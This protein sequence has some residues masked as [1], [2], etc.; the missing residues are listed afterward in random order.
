MKNL[1]TKQGQWKLKCV[2]KDGIKY[3]VSDGKSSRKNSWVTEEQ[4]LNEFPDFWDKL[5]DILYSKGEEKYWY[6]AIDYSKSILD[7]ICVWGWVS[8]KQFDSIMMIV[9]SKDRFNQSKIDKNRRM[10]EYKNTLSFKGNGISFTT[11]SSDMLGMRIKNASSDKDMDSIHKEIFGTRPMFSEELEGYSI[12]YRDDG[13][14][15]F[16]LP[17]GDENL[18]DYVF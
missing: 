12:S 15:Y 14:R 16:S 13:S 17:M 9:N 3:P 8:W 4:I 5:L 18:C 7:F 6:K 11:Q 2:I 1:E 10:V